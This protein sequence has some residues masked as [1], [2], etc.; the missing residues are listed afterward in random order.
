MAV[1]AGTLFFPSDK[2]SQPAL[3]PSCWDVLPTWP[4]HPLPEDT[5]ML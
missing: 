3:A 4:R 1:I 5:R 2:L